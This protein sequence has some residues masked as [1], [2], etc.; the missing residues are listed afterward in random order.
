VETVLAV[1]DELTR[2]GRTRW[3]QGASEVERRALREAETR[4]RRV[5]PVRSGAPL[6]LA[7]SAFAA[8]WRKSV[9]RTAEAGGTAST[10]P[11]TFAEDVA[12]RV[13]ARESSGSVGARAVGRLQKSVRG[14]FSASPAEPARAT[15]TASGSTDRPLLVTVEPE[16]FGRQGCW[17]NERKPEQRALT[18]P[19]RQQCRASIRWKASWADEPNCPK[20]AVGYRV[21]AVQEP[22]SAQAGACSAGCGIQ[23]DPAP[24]LRCD[25]GRQRSRRSVSLSQPKGAEGRQPPVRANARAVLHRIARGRSSC[26]EQ[27][28]GILMAAAAARTA[29]PAGGSRRKTMVSALQRSALGSQTTE[30]PKEAP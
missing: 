2:A 24:A 20:Q 12:R 27:H 13:R 5:G 9:E 26:G 21:L 1:W 22:D 16:R 23:G 10:E 17:V 4:P 14:I 3:R 30:R 8:P 7:E 15:S 29:Q 28:R 18:S 6:P 11:S 25:K 19:V